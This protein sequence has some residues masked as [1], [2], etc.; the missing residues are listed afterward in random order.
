MKKF[1]LTL[2]TI[3]TLLVVSACASNPNTK[4]ENNNN[5]ENSTVDGDTIKIEINNMEFPLETK[6]KKGQKVEWTNKDS[7]GHTVTFSTIDVDS[8]SIP[9]GGKFTQQF[10]QTGTFDYTC[11]FHP[12][13]RGIII[14]E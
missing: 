3:S 11:T 9:T 7:V 14:V 8:G 13:M 2:V 12:A 1:V 10:N 5:S 4:V 6:I